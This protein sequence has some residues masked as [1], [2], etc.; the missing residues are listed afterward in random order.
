MKELLTTA[1]EDALPLS[2]LREAGKAFSIAIIESKEASDELRT[3]VKIIRR[4]HYRA[5]ALAAVFVIFGLWIYTHFRYELRLERERAAY[6]SQFEDN[7]EVLLELAKS[8]RKLDL[9]KEDK[10]K[11]LVIK[12]ATGWTSTN[13]NG[14][15]ELKE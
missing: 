12:D 9:V 8:R 7:R 6:I 10:R 4:A 5:Y 2:D 13:G 11:M 3:N 1:M 14:V 15:I